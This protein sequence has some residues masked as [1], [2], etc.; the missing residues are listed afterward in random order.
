M[1]V[2]LDLTK[3]VTLQIDQDTNSA[4]TLYQFNVYNMVLDAPSNSWIPH[5]AYV[6]QTTAN[7]VVLPSDVFVDGNV[8]MIRGET[9]VGGFPGIA[10][11]DLTMRQLPLSVGY[12]DGGIFTAKA[13]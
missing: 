5:V 8:Y 3:P 11:G 12:L 1:T 7:T 6:A 9:L 10:T 13:Q 2:T 4:P